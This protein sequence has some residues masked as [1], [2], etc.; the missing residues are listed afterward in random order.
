M[1]TLTLFQVAGVAVFALSGSLG[2]ALAGKWTRDAA[3]SV[4]WPV[5][6]AWLNRNITNPSSRA[7]ML[8][9]MGQ[10]D[11]VGQVLGG[12][13]LGVVANRAGVQAALLLAAVI[14]APAAILYARLPRATS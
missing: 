3:Q 4:S 1:A 2:M 5:S 8:S 7:T 9:M 11:A 10:A 12:P 13:S 14:Q 6:R